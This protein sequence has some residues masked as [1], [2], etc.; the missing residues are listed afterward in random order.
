MVN[1]F[2]PRLPA[3]AVA[4]GDLVITESH[5]NIEEYVVW[6]WRVLTNVHLYG[7]SLM[8]SSC[9]NKEHVY[10]KSSCILEFVVFDDVLLGTCR[11][12]LWLFPF[13]SLL[14]FFRILPSCRPEQ[15]AQG[16]KTCGRCSASHPLVLVPIGS[17][18][19]GYFLILSTGSV[20]SMSLAPRSWLWDPG[21]KRR[22]AYCTSHS[23]SK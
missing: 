11:L 9:I 23:S 5:K 16:R 22:T 17:G 2:L 13:L 4:A 6:V 1:L 14:L 8:S 21:R 3:A 15:M 12:D 18:F 10:R 7:F 20:P 19:I